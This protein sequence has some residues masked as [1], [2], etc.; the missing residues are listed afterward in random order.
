[1]AS[2]KKDKTMWAKRRWER[3]N[4]RED[5]IRFNAEERFIAAAHDKEAVNQR[6][7]A[8]KRDR[9]KRADGKP[10]VPTEHQEQAA[11]IAW[12]YA[13]HSKYRL[14]LF[15]LFACP[16]G[17]ARDAITGS[18]LKA[19]GVRPGTPDLILVVP[20]PA[21]SALFLEMKK[22]DGAKPTP[23]QTAFIEYLRSAG[24]SAGVHYGAI[25]A[26]KEIEDYLSA[27]LP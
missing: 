7:I 25:S 24:Y 8:P 18:L 19:E 21:F 16:N 22:T 13:V 17:G 4:K 15:T 14:P 27:L 26:I 23:E 12:W 6:V 9:I 1:M 20:T 10:L 3:P 5:A 11:V 2:P